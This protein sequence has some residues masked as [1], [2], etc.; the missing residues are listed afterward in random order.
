MK[1]KQLSGKL[2]CIGKKNICFAGPTSFSGYDINY[3]N[4][5][6]QVQGSAQIPC[7][8]L[9]WL[10]FVWVVLPVLY[11]SCIM[12]CLSFSRLKSCQIIAETWWW[13]KTNDIHKIQLFWWCSPRDSTH[14]WPISVVP[15]NYVCWFITPIDYTDMF[16]IWTLLMLVVN[17]LSSLT[18]VPPCNYSSL[19]CPIAPYY[20]LI[21]PPFLLVKASISEVVSCWPFRVSWNIPELNECF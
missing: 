11:H 17:Q 4:L 15:S 7:N 13:V 18:G 10:F 19:Y 6:P 5:N 16:I 9:Q 3:T 21:I 1:K 14:F 12:L 20:N 8:F 2:A